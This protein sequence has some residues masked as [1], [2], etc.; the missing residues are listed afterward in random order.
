MIIELFE[1]A[2]RVNTEGLKIVCVPTSFQV[3]SLQYIE[4]ECLFIM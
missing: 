1:I 2:H 3:E 4:K